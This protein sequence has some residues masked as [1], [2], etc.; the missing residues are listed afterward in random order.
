[1]S[2]AALLLSDGRFPSGGHAHSGGLEPAATAG[3]VT[4][5]TS[6]GAFL[7]GRLATA[8]LTAA[9]LAAAASCAGHSWPRL[10]AEAD[11]RISS[12]ALR[13]SSR[14]QGRQ[15]LRAGRATWGGAGLD[16]LAVATANQPHHAIALGALGAAAGLTTAEVATSA[17]YGS[18]S[19][20]AGA[21]VRLL[22]L[23]PFAVQAVLS[24]MAPDIDAV[25]AE[26]AM[27]ALGA[28]AD[29]PAAGAPLLDALAEDH[30]TWE[31][32]LFA[33]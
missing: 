1:M 6:L 9:G 33:S 29:L 22:G 32:K 2:T 14:Q 8:G 24:R 26:A 12:P 25:A 31:V 30:A 20:P 19:G 11:A 17:A 13:L 15:L 18:V 7:A 5:V 28:L 16:R 21:A 23:D 4:D 10:D 27:A 3:G